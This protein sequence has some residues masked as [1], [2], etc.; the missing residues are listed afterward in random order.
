M[1]YNLLNVVLA[2]SAGTAIGFNVINSTIK[3]SYNPESQGKIYQVC[4]YYPKRTK[5]LTTIAS[6]AILGL[7]E[8]AR[9]RRER[10]F[11]ENSRMY[12][13]S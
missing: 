5:V 2:A 10:R 12:L 7:A 6:G 4:R 11:I 8:I 9:Q 13:R 3:D 1:R